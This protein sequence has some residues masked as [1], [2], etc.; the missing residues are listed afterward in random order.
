[1]LNPGARALLRKVINKIYEDQL[2]DY[3]R[4]GSWTDLMHSLEIGLKY[5]LFEIEALKREIKALE[6]S[7]KNLRSLLREI[8]PKD[9]EDEKSSD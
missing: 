2:A 9:G 7:N 8:G 3:S 4:P 6:K 1:M 5:Y